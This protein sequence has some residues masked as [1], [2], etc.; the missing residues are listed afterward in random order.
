MQ[1]PP[2]SIVVGGCCG[3]M[4][5]LIVEEAA[6]DP[7]HFKLVGGFEQ[8]AHPAVGQPLA[9]HPT[10]KV[11]S[12]LKAVLKNADLLIEF[13]TPES[14]VNNAKVCAEVSVPVLM[15]T[16]GFSP[17][18]MAQLRALASRIPIF[19]SPNM[20][21]GIVMIRKTLGSLFDLY[22][23][24]GL[25]KTLSIKISETHHAKKK[26]SPSGTAKQLAQD[27]QHITGQPIRD[28]EIEA[29]REGEVVGIHRVTFEAGAERIDLRHEV[30]DR[31]VFA[32]GA[33]LVARNFEKIRNRQGGGWYGM[34]DFVS[35][36]QRGEAP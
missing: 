22:R 35:A 5:S 17:D 18:Q 12:D 14:S 15:G 25:D 11:T 23:K 27:L 16:T 1:K 7:V 9:N 21:I 36:V 13:T 32:Q 3:R 26:D 24:F 34:D 4:G 28:N 30:I 2:L 33:L 19:W 8:A 6:K 31:R 20:S 29:Q 10:L